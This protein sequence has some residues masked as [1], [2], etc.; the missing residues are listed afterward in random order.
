MLVLCVIVASQETIYVCQAG[1]PKFLGAYVMSTDKFD[2]VSIYSNE[3]DMSFCKYA[4]IL[5]FLL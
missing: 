4:D 2:G 5:S 1:D 3:N